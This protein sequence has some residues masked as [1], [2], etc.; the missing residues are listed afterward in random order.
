MLANLRHILGISNFYTGLNI[1]KIIGKWIYYEENKS[2]RFGTALE[3][4][5]RVYNFKLFSLRIYL[6][7]ST[8]PK[9]STKDMSYMIL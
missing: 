4:S 9:F 8:K 2:Y 6:L 1:T 5:L 3:L 7:D